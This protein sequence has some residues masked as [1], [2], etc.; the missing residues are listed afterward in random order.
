[1]LDKFFKKESPL[2]GLLGLGGGI[3]R[4]SAAGFESSGGTKI[5][6]GADVIHVFTSPDTLTFNDLYTDAKIILV[7]GGGAGGYHRANSA[8]QGHYATGGGGAG[9]VYVET[10]STFS[11]GSYAI[12]IGAGGANQ[13]SDPV[14]SPNGVGANGSDSTA[15]GKRAYG[16]GGG[17]NAPETGNPGGSGGG[18]GSTGSPGSGGVGDRQAGNRPPNTPPGA[19]PTPL[20]PQGFP[21]GQ[22]YDAGPAPERFAGGG[23]GA[24]GAGQTGFPSGSPRGAGGIGKGVDWLPSDYGTPGPDG[25]TRYFGGG[26]GA[27]PQHPG[28][29]SA[30]GGYGGGGAGNNNPGDSEHATPGTAN[31]GGGGGAKSNKNDGAGKGY[32]GSGG[33]GFFAIRFTG[34]G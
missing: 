11:A 27:A 1:M 3:A 34:V 19:I 7:A 31:T 18:C 29:P 2:L 30:P 17:G 32:N 12:S 10:G 24:G 33:P 16:G 14:S 21:G 26:G 15:L 25:S 22:G 9:G 5:V 20:Q 6:V 13:T 8:G 4:G 23:G 28:T